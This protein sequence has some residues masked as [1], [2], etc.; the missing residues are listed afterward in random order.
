[1]SVKA[2]VLIIGGGIAGVSIAREL[3]RYDLHV[4]LAEKE[5]DV[6]WGQTKVSYA[7]RHPGARWPPGTLA[8]E[9]VVKSNLIL[10]QLIEELDIDFRR[11]G[12]LILAFNRDE[13]ES[14]KIIKS[15]GENFQVQGLKRDDLITLY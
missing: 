14:L 5:A 8:Q 11:C 1:M 3:S 2:D 9:L 4:V 13:L 10:D 15:Q 6:G 7:I 12:E